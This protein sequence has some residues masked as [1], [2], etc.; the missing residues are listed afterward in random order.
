MR[1]LLIGTELSTVTL[2]DGRYS[3]RNVPLG[4]Q[5]VRVLRVGYREQK[6]AA[7]VGA[8]ATVGV[9]FVLERT[10]VQ[11]E[12]IVSTATGSRPREELGNAVA[13]LSAAK[14]TETAPITNV[15]DVI[16]AR[17]PGMT[18]QAGSQV[19]GGGRIRIR[20]NGSLNLSNDP[21][22]IIDGI[23]A[24]SNAGSMSNGTGGAH[25]TGSTI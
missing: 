21:I 7:N 5:T 15:Q 16:A 23:R 11:L 4:P 17:V 8:N 14:I 6:K 18:V 1:V 9:D 20:G 13:S 19:G 10:V 24:T 22:Y 25:R 3:I 12:E 2:Q